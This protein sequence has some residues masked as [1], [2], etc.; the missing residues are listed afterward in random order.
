MITKQLI[1]D[2]LGAGAE[3][4]IY[5]EYFRISGQIRPGVYHKNPVSACHSNTLKFFVDN[6]GGLRFM[7]FS[8]NRSDFRGDVIDAVMLM[9]NLDYQSAL[10]D[11][12]STF[13]LGLALYKDYV[14]ED[15]KVEE[16][17]PYEVL[18]TE[19]EVV[20]QNLTGYD[21]IY[22]E[23]YHIDLAQLPKFNV[24]SCKAAFVNGELWNT[25]SKHRPLFVYE[26]A[27]KYKV[28]SPLSRKKRKWRTNITKDLIAGYNSLPLE[29]HSLIIGSSVKDC[30]VFATHGYNTISYQGEGVIP[31]SIE[32]LI[33][34]F[35]T[36]Y[37]WL[38]CDAAGITATNKWKELHP[39]IIP[40]YWQ[41][42]EK[43]ISDYSKAFGYSRTSQL[44]TTYV[45]RR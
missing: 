12:D 19:I 25:S 2:K 36:I 35:D 20:K 30:L 6:R 23:D 43:D 1:L 42:S 34:R 7:D 10:L 41:S 33:K 21:K 29:G 22:F 28:Y 16:Y 32:E 37:V 8:P 9:T 31:E 18:E 14:P 39:N 27:G 40:V 11:I 26:I 5:K 44:L 17:T 45:K 24:S 15:R 4:L 3:E 38:D 13:K